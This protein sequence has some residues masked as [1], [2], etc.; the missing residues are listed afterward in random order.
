MLVPAPE[1]IQLRAQIGVVKSYIHPIFPGYF[2]TGLAIFQ[3]KRKPGKGP[4]RSL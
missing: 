2:F 1:I 4:Y 3:A